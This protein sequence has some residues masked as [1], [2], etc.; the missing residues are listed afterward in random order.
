MGRMGLGGALGNSRGVV[1]VSVRGYRMALAGFGVVLGGFLN[2]RGGS[3]AHWSLWG[4]HHSSNLH[5]SRWLVCS[6]GGYKACVSS[7]F[8]GTAA[9]GTG[10]NSHFER[11]GSTWAGQIAHFGRTG[12]AETGLNTERPFRAHWRHLSRLEQPFGGCTVQHW[13]RPERPFRAP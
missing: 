9:S 6:M 7:H 13:G 8:K 3:W 5:T 11:T 12:G 1:G 10:L 2:G 4:V